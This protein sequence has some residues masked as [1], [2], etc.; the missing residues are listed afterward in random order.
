MATLQYNGNNVAIL[1]VIRNSEP[2]SHRILVIEQVAPNYKDIKWLTA[3]G[4]RASQKWNALI[5]EQLKRR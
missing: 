4:Y 2:C 3:I 1:D 5:C